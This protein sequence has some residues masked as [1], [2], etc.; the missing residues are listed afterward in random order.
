MES[1]ATTPVSLDLVPIELIAPRLKRVATVAVLIGVVIGAIVG[2][3]TSLWVGVLV[4]AVI[5]VPTAAPALVALRRRITLQQGRIRSTGGIR[6]RQVD[7]TRAVT[8]E[9]VVRSARVS[10]VSLRITDPDGSLALPLALYTNDGGRELEVLGLR[11]LADALAQSELVPAAAVASVLIEQL[12][13]EARSAPLPERPLFR[14]VELVRSEGRLPA[15][16]LTDH[17]VAGLVD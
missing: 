13:A 2:F 4:G 10:E 3:F 17:E 7:A 6:S 11:R 14:A 15:T 5:A 16:T 9:I 8:V 1:D 12:R